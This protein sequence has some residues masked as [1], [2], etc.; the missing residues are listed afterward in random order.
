QSRLEAARAA[1]RQASASEPAALPA[2]RAEA[3]VTTDDLVTEEAQAGA[4]AAAPELPEVIDLRTIRTVRAAAQLSAFVPG[5]DLPRRWGH[6]PPA[7]VA[8]LLQRQAAM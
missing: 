1:R 7:S 4:P 8:L 2:P 5:T 6:T 3:D